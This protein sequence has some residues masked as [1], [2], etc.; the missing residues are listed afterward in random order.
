M[1]KTS[2]PLI[3]ASALLLILLFAVGLSPAQAQTHWLV[4]RWDG[5]IEGMAAKQKPAR[6]LRV[7]TVEADNTAKARWA[8][9]GEN[10]GSVDARVD[11]S[12]ISFVVASSKSVVELSREGDDSLAGKITFANGKSFPVKLTRVKL[13]NTFD[14]DWQGSVT[15]L[16]GCGSATYN[17]KVTDSLITG[18]LRLTF[19]G[20][21]TEPASFFDSD[22]TGEVDSR[23]AAVIEIRGRRNAVFPGTFTSTE[24]RGTDPTDSRGCSYDIVLTRR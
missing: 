6:T 4:G 2:I 22:I 13:S 9:T 15:V 11:G 16:R 18:G 3:A 7:H 24:F 1:K 21:G 17:F 8:I 20:Y 19:A 12:Q 5:S 23:G 10:T 14:G